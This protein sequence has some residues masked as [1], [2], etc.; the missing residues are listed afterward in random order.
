MKFNKN[1]ALR[2]VAYVMS[3]IMISQAL[4]SPT[5]MVYANAGDATASQQET[6]QVEN[7]NGGGTTL[8]RITRASRARAARALR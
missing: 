6:T 2:A 3:A 8:P 5:S 4:L 1:R 7:S